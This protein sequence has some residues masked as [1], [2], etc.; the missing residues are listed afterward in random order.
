MVMGGAGRAFGRIAPIVRPVMKLPGKPTGGSGF[1]CGNDDGGNGGDATPAKGPADNSDGDNPLVSMWKAYNSKLESDPL[2][3]KM[4]TSFTGFLLGDIIAQTCITKGDFDWFR[5]FRLSSFGFFVH[6]S[7]S[8]YFYNFLDGKIPGTTAAAVASK[9]FIDQVIWNPIFGVMFFG[10]VA[11]LEGKGLPFV[12]EKI[13]KE[14]LVSV[15]YLPPPIAPHLLS[16]PAA[17]ALRALRRVLVLPQVT[18]SWKVWPIAHTINFRFI[19]SSQRVLYINSIQI[20]Y[21]CFLS[22]ISSRD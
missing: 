10:Y 15:R 8:H 1:G 4:L 7:T 3:M 13:K 19:P 14:L 11:A 21:N 6:G 18:G 22:V 9:V 20:G 5:L 12:V 16:L 2:I 17:H